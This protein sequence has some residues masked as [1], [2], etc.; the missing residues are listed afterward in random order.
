MNVL[1][2]KVRANIHHYCGLQMFCKPQLQLHTPIT[3]LWLPSTT[4]THK[5]TETRTHS[6][7]SYIFLAIHQQLTLKINSIMYHTSPLL[8]TTSLT[9]STAHTSE[10]SQTHCIYIRLTCMQG[11]TFNVCFLHFTGAYFTLSG[12]IKKKSFSLRFH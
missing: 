2:E 5:H 4:H 1:R 3:F 11:N 8:R 12:S 7:S 10:C 6:L 9:Y